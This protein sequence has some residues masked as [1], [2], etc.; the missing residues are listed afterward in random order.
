M[1]CINWGIIAPGHIAHKMAEAMQKSKLNLNLNINLYAVASRPFDV[2]G[3]EYQLIHATECISKGI[4]ESDVHSFQ[5][6]IELCEIMDMLRK[7]WGLK[8]PFEK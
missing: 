4:L 6:S 2:N 8:Y 7:D 1:K 5:R 3:F